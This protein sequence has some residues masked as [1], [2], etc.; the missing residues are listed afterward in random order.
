MSSLYKV[1]DSARVLRKDARIRR[2]HSECSPAAC[3]SGLPPP[4]PTPLPLLLPC[5]PAPAPAPPPPPVCAMGGGGR[6]A[7]RAKSGEAE[8]T[9]PPDP[10]QARRSER[11]ALCSQG[12]QRPR[13]ESGFRGKDWEVAATTPARVRR[14]SLSVSTAAAGRPAGGGSGGGGPDRGWGMP[15]AR[16]SRGGQRLKST[17]KGALCPAAQRERRW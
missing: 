14:S 4:L 7:G 10:I 16:Q 12:P 8:P 17:R 3:E 15:A 1:P 13:P 5:S 2:C 11:P 6:A 9:L